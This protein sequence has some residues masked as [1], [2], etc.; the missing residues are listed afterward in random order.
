MYTVQEGGEDLMKAQY[1]LKEFFCDLKLIPGVL[2]ANDTTTMNTDTSI[3]SPEID[4]LSYTS[5]LAFA[6]LLR[7]DFNPIEIFERI[8]VNVPDKKNTENPRT[9][10]YILRAAICAREHWIV[11]IYFLAFLRLSS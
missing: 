9:L 11:P 8:L 1:I 5:D 6:S 2:L 3:N 7:L 10:S 4:S